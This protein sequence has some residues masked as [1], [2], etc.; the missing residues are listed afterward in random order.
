MVHLEKAADKSFSSSL[1]LSLITGKP[2]QI[3][4]IRAAAK[5]RV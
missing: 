3:R 1:A 4:N 2:F 5:I